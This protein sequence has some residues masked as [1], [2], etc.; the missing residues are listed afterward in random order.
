MLHKIMYR[1]APLLLVLL[2]ACSQPSIKSEFDVLESAQIVPPV[3][4]Q[5]LTLYT[6][7]DS[8]ALSVQ[9][10]KRNGIYLSTLQSVDFRGKPF[11]NITF[12]SPRE[13][14]NIWEFA[15]TLTGDEWKNDG[16]ESPWG[17]NSS[18]A[19]TARSVIISYGVG[20]DKLLQFK[21]TL[22]ALGGEENLDSI[23]SPFSTTF[24]FKDKAGNFWDTATA[25]K[26][27]T[28]EVNSYRNRYEEIYK[29]NNTPALLEASEK[30]WAA[31]TSFRRDVVVRE[32]NSIETTS[33]DLSHNYSMAD[34]TDTNGNLNM[35]FVRNV[36]P[37]Q[38]ESQQVS[39]LSTQNYNQGQSCYWI[40]WWRVC[41]T[42][43][44]GSISYA[45]QASHSG[46]YQRPKNLGHP[47]NTQFQMPHCGILGGVEQKA[48]VGCAPAAFM[49][50]I[51][52]EWANGEIFY[53]KSYNGEP[54]GSYQSTSILVDMTQP[55]SYY[56]RPQIASY[57]GT[58]WFLNGSATTAW[59]FVNGANNFLRD[60]G[61][62]AASR[63]VGNRMR[64][65]YNYSHAFGNLWSV[66]A[67]ADIV[68]EYIGRRN[69]P[70]ILEYWPNASLAGG[71]FSPITEYRY[72]E[73][74]GFKSLMLKTMDHATTW[75]SV[76][77]F[78]LPQ[79]GVF[80]IER[81]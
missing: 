43:E 3:A 51:W 59:D 68:R 13:I 35:D 20:L 14:N 42:T 49:G 45:N 47:A 78:W 28:Q 36:L 31:I 1:I 37:E 21:K 27:T 34:F 73:D 66:G 46:Y 24:L 57:M 76:V 79:V 11:I 48:P 8:G 50:V 81:Y 72:S 33:Q 23:V 56:N 77:A 12:T 19:S 63:G 16:E 30:N 10:V 44:T 69:K 15:S 41:R 61:K 39:D 65:K 74:L 29:E 58:C 64:I 55:S 6:M 32:S 2:A 53:G 22:D 52:R 7:L 40:L 25:T 67:K 26:I 18:G 80:T 4:S 62:Q 38:L 5:G 60:H 17:F 9:S 54:A 71:H 70:V 75:Q